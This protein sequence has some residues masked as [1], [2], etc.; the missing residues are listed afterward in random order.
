MS[1]KLLYIIIFLLF[2]L[3]C[4]KREKQI[5]VEYDKAF[6]ENICYDK[7]SYIDSL[8]NKNTN[9]IIYQ[10]NGDCSTCILDF[11][12]WIQNSTKYLKETPVFIICSSYDLLYTTYC[13]EENN[14][15][16]PSNFLLLLDKNKD[17]YKDHLYISKSVNIYASN[18]CILVGI[19]NHILDEGNAYQNRKLFIF[20]KKLGILSKNLRFKNVNYLH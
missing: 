2:I 9:K 12:C 14:I 7:V 13:L 19:N 6:L 1:R 4:C 3:S 11:L 16:L 15:K 8:W 20:Y 5:G 18:L 17:F 10:Y